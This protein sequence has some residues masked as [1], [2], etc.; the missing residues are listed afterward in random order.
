[1]KVYA[2]AVFVGGVKRFGGTM[3]ADSVEEAVIKVAKRNKLTVE[4]NGSVVRPCDGATIQLAEW[5]LEGK[6]ASVCIWAPPEY[7]LN[8]GI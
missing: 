6:K 1:M 5:T 7:F 4:D 3:H 8:S 2:Y